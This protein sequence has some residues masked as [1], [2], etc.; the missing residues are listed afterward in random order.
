[1]VQ[2]PDNIGGVVM[3]FASGVNRDVTQDLVDALEATISTDVVNGESIS[4]LWVS[5]AKDRHKC[6]SRHVTGNGIDIS[7]VNDKH[8]S[9]H[10]N[11][12]D[13]VK[14]IVDG[15]QH[16]FEKAPKRRENFGPTVQ[17]KEGRSYPTPDH[18]DH[19][20]WSVSG[21]HSACA[22]PLW[23]RLLNFFKAEQTPP[24]ADRDE[25]CEI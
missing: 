21:D 20:H 4:K 5:S 14:S 6:P 18:D 15:L 9:L 10:Y 13:S 12:D 24:S 11:N 8:I 23:Q 2:I 7:R 25:I 3:E 17:L 16:K 22:K 1:M 19:V